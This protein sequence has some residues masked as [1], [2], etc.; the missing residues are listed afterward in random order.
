MRSMTGDHMLLVVSV[1][2]Q[3]FEKQDCEPVA[4]EEDFYDE[5]KRKAMLAVV[6][7]VFRGVSAKVV[8]CRG[9]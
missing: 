2:V 5:E 9:T 7:A 6:Q 3:S 4:V 8:G 1:W